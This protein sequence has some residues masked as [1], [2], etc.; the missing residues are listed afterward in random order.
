MNLYKLAK[1]AVPAI[2]TIYVLELN[3]ANTLHS[4]YRFISDIDINFHNN[5]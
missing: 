4:C 1:K 3:D 5:A 2:I